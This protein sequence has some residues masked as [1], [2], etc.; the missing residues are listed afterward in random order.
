[1]SKICFSCGAK[2]E[3]EAIFCDEC[4][5]KQSDTQA[6]QQSEFITQ[7]QNPQLSFSIGS[8]PLN[9]Q[10]PSVDLQS[11]SVNQVPNT[12]K[13]SGMGIASF[14]LGIIAI[15][16]FGCLIISDILSFVFSII[17]LREKNTKHGLAIAGL[18]MSVISVLLFILL[19]IIGGS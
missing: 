12:M 9:E 17:A 2:L 4:G 19:I 11:D 16:S 14:V 1:M 3:E 15:C 13:N 8:K 7:Q 18:I 6:S 5:A 10:R